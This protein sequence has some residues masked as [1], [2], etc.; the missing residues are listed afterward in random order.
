M[1]V[2][3]KIESSKKDIW[4][5][6]QE[7]NHRFWFLYDNQDMEYKLTQTVVKSL[8]QRYFNNLFLVVS[9]LNHQPIKSDSKLMS[10]L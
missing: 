2:N 8:L 6:T 5:L 1:S 4:K 10:Y 9:Q 7:L 3:I